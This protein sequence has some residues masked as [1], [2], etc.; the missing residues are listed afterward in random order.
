[1]LPLNIMK[2]KKTYKTISFDV[3]QF[4]LIKSYCDKNC[5][6]MTKWILNLT[7]NEINK[8]NKL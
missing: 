1:M 8:K 4:N 7:L 5:L 2:K 6:N 3:D